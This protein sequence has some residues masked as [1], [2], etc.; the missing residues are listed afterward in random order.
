[1]AD[2]HLTKI[3]R[4]EDLVFNVTLLLILIGAGFYRKLWMPISYPPQG[5]YQSLRMLTWLENVGIITILD[6]WLRNVK[7]W[8]IRFRNLFRPNTYAN[9]CKE[10]TA[11][12]TICP[13]TVKSH[14]K[15]M[16]DARIIIP[17][18]AMMRVIVVVLLSN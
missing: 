18:E 14:Q 12:W 10:T 6:I 4:L 9:S 5:R 15:E 8:K 7:M 17:S 13:N 16:K 1:M 2:L 11:T 3:G